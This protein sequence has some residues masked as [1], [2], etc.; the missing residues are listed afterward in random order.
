MAILDEGRVVEQGDVAQVFA[1]PQS[2]AAKK[3]VFPN[4]EE[5]VLPPQQNEARLRIIF[6]GSETAELPLIATMAAQHGI[7]AN[8]LGAS[9]RAFHAQAF[10]EMLIGVPLA[11]RQ[12]ALDYL[13][14]V[15]GIT[16]EEVPEDVQ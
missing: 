8:I 3:L 15:A 1:H 11:Q 4:G 13:K 7:M 10:G 9:T 6:N 16:V 5:T 12:Q 2:D 14:T